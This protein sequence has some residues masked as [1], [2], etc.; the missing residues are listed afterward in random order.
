MS[1]ENS[2]PPFDAS[3]VK[4]F[5]TARDRIINPFFVGRE[6]IMTLVNDC[7]ESVNMRRQ[8]KAKGHPAEGLMRLIQGPRASAR[9]L[10]CA[11][12]N[13]ATFRH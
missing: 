9:V 6:G 4:D 13:I 11:N 7:L 10:S 5:I 12:S 1:D 2:R 3:G 8:K